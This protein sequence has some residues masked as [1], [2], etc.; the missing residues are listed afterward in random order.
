MTDW[1]P[2]VSDGARCV[3]D[4][5]ADVCGETQRRRRR[6]QSRSCQT[7]EPQSPTRPTKLTINSRTQTDPPTA[8][9]S[10][11]S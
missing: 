3:L 8:A 2:G 1:W 6:A 10:P 5:L 9:V 7:D 4:T 11:S